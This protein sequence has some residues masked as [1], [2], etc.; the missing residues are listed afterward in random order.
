M[1]AE[2]DKYHRPVTKRY[3]PSEYDKE[4]MRTG[5]MTNVDLCARCHVEETE[6]PFR[7]YSVSE[8]VQN[9]YPTA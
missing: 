5:W 8:T 1:N 2:H 9:W 6:W 3:E 4:A 7:P